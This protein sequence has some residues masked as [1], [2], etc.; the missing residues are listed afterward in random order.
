MM[1]SLWKRLTVLVACAVLCATAT[2]HELTVM[3]SGGFSAAFE[4]LAP[5]Y[6]EQAGVEIQTVHGPSMGKTP[7]SIPSRLKRGE[8]ADVVI[9]V[10]S[11]L[12]KLIDAGQVDPASRVELAD[13]RIGMVVRSGAPK[14]NIDTVAQF[15]DALLQA[16]SVAYSDSASGVY[17]ENQLF[18]TLGIEQAMRAKSSKIER[19]PVGSVVA[20]GRYQLGFQQVAEL[21]PVRNVEFVGRIPE[22]LQSITRYAAGVPV[23]SEHPEAAKRLLQYLQSEQA[24]TVARQTGLDPVSP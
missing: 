21:L 10:G 2:A 5:Q 3:T 11:A 9:M 1:K 19:I 18:K 24:Q 23:T 15:K 12:Q 17:I 6:S 22:A 8:H 20:D 16:R 4:R 13:S 14:P 7:Q